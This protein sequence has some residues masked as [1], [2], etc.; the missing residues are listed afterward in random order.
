MAIAVIGMQSGIELGYT[1]NWARA[2]RTCEKLILQKMNILVS[3]EVGYFRP[4]NNKLSTL[5]PS[6]MSNPSVTLQIYSKQKIKKLHFLYL[7]TV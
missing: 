3:Y 1:S 4:K 7:C 6:D 2:T 5:R